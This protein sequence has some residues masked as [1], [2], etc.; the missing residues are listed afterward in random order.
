MMNIIGKYIHDLIDNNRTVSKKLR[1]CNRTI[2]S[3]PPSD[4]S[5]HSSDCESININTVR[6]KIVNPMPTAH[7]PT[8][9]ETNIHQA[10]NMPPH[11][12]HQKRP[13]GRPSGSTVVKKKKKP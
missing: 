10:Y 13:T 5:I 4:I 6:R 3:C 1:K 2:I 8:A 9:N 11:L 7:L 12:L